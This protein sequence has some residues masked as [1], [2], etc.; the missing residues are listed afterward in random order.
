V[1]HADTLHDH[2]APDT[3]APPAG[4]RGFLARLD[5]VKEIRPG[6]WRAKCPAHDGKS[7]GSLSVSETP[8]GTV[9]V[10]CWGGCDL[11]AI[12]V[13]VGLEPRD[14]FPARNLTTQAKRK[15][16]RR[17]TERDIRRALRHEL[18]VFQQGNDAHIGGWPIED[19]DPIERERLSVQRIQNGLR[20]LYD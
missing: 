13:S 18:L 20:R 5:H 9:L 16:A 4:A 7:D 15:Y 3:A 8:D 17:M 12:A 14:F 2:R 10:R 6:Q 11:A 19:P 1:I